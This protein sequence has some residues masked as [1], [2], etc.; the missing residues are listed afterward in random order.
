MTTFSQTADRRQ[1]PPRPRIP[2]APAAGALILCWLA[3]TPSL[4]PR[5]AL[6]QGLLCAVAAGIGYAIGALAGWLLRSL[7]VHLTGRPRR[8]AWRTLAIIAVVGS[9]AIFIWYL[10]WQQQLREAIGLE[11]LSY[12]HL[13]MLVVSAVLLAI[14][15]LAIARLLRLAGRAVGRQIDRVLPT[16]PAAV[17]GALIVAGLAWL[18]IDGLVTGRLLER[19]DSAFVA[20][21]NEFTTDRAAPEL[22][23]VSGGPASA[24][25]WEDL[26]RQGRIFIG[27][28]PTAAQIE[29]F[30]GRAAEQPVRAYVGV[31]VDGHIDLPEEAEAAVDELERTGG[32]DRQVIN[33]ATGTGRGWVNENQAAALEYMWNGDTATVSM[34]YSYLPSW[35]SF[36]VDQTR[37]QDAGR[38]LFE[39]VYERWLSLPADDRPLLVVSGESLGSFGGEAAFGGEADLVERTDGAFFVGPTSNNR[40]WSRFTAERDPGSPQVLPVY[41]EGSTVR[42]ADSPDD[43]N[44]PSPEWAV[45]RIG[46]L[47]YA[48][49]PVTW[50]NWDLALHRPDWLRE[51]LGRDVPEQMRWLPVVTMLQVA[52]DQ[53]VANS[54][55]DGQGHEFGQAPVYGWAKIL[56]PDGWDES[57]TERLARA[58]AGHEDLGR[59]PS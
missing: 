49:D 46:Y 45:P 10:R 52:A 57:D 23:T 39:A 11:K 58:V 21:N 41:R 54:V 1:H 40:L 50:W 29:E 16:K 56:P 48:N 3:L 53:L 47:Q 27:N 2:F 36:L 51:P 33:V 34:Q 55:P 19:L 32:F 43:W 31:G 35:L 13:T 17:L 44:R 30:S 4:L 38:L 25:D 37:S 18:L 42:F 12:G 22:E 15:F 7:G 20:I 5:P 24:Q 6:F 8:V 26:G 28:T 59:P 14:V 9:I